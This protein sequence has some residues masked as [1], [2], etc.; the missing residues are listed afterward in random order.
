V[1][2]KA[3]PWSLAGMTAEERLREL[4]QGSEWP[5]AGGGAP[6]DH[7]AVCGYLI[8]STGAWRAIRYYAIHG[9][10]LDCYYK[11]VPLRKLHAVA[12]E[13]MR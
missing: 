8:G 7:C 10:C 5:W 11:W 12:E 2:Q 9:V 4:A 3:N 6:S 1:G 13:L